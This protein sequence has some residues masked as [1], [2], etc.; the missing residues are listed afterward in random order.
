MEV[1]DRD[2][3]IHTVASEP[4]AE[5][6]EHDCDVIAFEELTDVRER[7]PQAKCHHAWAFRRLYEYVSDRAPEQ[8][9]SVE[10]VVPNHT[11]QR[12]SRTD[13]G[14]THEDNHRGEQFTRAELS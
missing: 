5:A 7:L 10:Q 12:C 4:V 13:C 6:V 9:V 11:P 2:P 14:F 8:G 3:N 1:V